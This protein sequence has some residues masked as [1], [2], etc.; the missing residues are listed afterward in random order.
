MRIPGGDSA[1][2]GVP[3]SLMRQLRAELA[4]RAANTARAVRADVSPDTL[5]LIAGQRIAIRE[6][7]RITAYDSAGVVVNPF[8]PALQLDGRSVVTLDRGQIVAVQPGSTRL[9][10]GAI[11]ERHSDGR[12]T[13]RP[14]GAIL[15]VVS[16]QLN[17]REDS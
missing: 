12:S 9:H 6:A 3:D 8:S 5:R 17:S 7:I 4:A 2:A 15:V 11:T 1:I 14:L 16:A 10:I 13:I